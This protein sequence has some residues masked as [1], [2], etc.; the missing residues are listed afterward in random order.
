MGLRQAD[1]RGYVWVKEAKLER[2]A[3]TSAWSEVDICLISSAQ[4]TGDCRLILFWANSNKQLLLLLLIQENWLA[5][6]FRVARIKLTLKF[7][8]S[9]MN[10]L[11]D[12]LFFFTNIHSLLLA[13]SFPP[14]LENKSMSKSSSI[15]GGWII[16]ILKW[17]TSSGFS[18]PFLSF[19]Q[20]QIR[21]FGRTKKERESSQSRLK[22]L[23]ER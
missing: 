5:D 12:C 8:S 11:F 20:T 3:V 17:W 18:N 9:S 16:V 23:D 21:T 10:N 19:G 4:I 6:M 13:I 2:L 15:N 14:S 1:G 7:Y 22:S